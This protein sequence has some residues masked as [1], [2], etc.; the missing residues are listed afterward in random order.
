MV[1]NT[2]NRQS[3]VIKSPYFFDLAIFQILGQTFVGF[4]MFFG[5][6][7]QRKIASDMK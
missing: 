7:M 1:L 2:K 3:N 5:E 6:L 4:W